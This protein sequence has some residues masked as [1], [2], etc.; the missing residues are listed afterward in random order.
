M[1][2]S[3]FESK[4]VLDPKD[5]QLVELLQKDARAGYAEL[6]RQVGL[7]APATAERVKRLEDAGVIRGYRAEVD[8]QKL[9]YAIEAVIRLRCDGSV[10][11]TLGPALADIP[12][13]LDYRRLAGEDSGSLRVVAMSVSHLEAV[14]DRIASFHSSI[15]TTTLVV[16]QTPYSNRSLSRAMWLQGSA[17]GQS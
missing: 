13:I 16:L 7:S 10:C 14:L 3:T 2:A 4:S 8:P 17:T 1:A 12:E 15:S 9:G 11:A 5:W 6:G